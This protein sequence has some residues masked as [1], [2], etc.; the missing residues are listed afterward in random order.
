MKLTSSGR[1]QSAAMMRSPSFSRSSS[2]MITAILPRRRSWRISSIVFIGPFPLTLAGLRQE[3]LQVSGHHIDLDVRAVADGELSQRRDLVRMR[4]DVDLEASAAH[5]VHRQ[6]HPVDADRSLG[7]DVAHEPLRQ[8]EAQPPG[9]RILDEVS[10][11]RD[12]IDVAAHQMSAERIAR[13]Q[14]RLEV[15]A[16]PRR[17]G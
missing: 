12:G 5:L 11:R 17:K 8:L 3:P 1:T 4:N 7:R 9:A 16:A 15:H 13:A 14:A 2:S 10:E 6:A